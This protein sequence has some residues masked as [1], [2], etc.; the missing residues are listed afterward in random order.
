M[1]TRWVAIDRR[2]IFL[3]IGLAVWAPFALG[4]SLPS[5]GANPHTRSVYQVIEQARP[6]QAIMIAFD[7]GPSGMAELHPMALALVRH[8]LRKN[9][10]VLAMTIDV[11]GSLMADEVFGALAREMPDKRYGTDYVNLGYKPGDVLVVLGMGEDIGRTFP[12]DAH[13]QATA[14]LPVMR[15]IRNYSTIRLVVDLS[16]SDTPGTWILFAHERFKQAVAAGVT[17]VMAT[18]FYPYLSTGQL[19]GMLNGL[20]GAAEYEGLIDHPDKAVLGM[21]S[22][23]AAH[24]AIIAFILL[25]NLGHFATTRQRRRGRGQDCL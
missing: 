5:G 7:Y 2:W 9:L 1:G 19:V 14:S 11:T 25:G 8:A 13:G 18:D 12:R 22:Q 20:K 21:T 16:H 24:L 17:A 3:T 4:L 15:G 23:S 6:G 10:R